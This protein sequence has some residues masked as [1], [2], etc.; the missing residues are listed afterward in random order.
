MLL[1]GS[2]V[3][4][5]LFLSLPLFLLLCMCVLNWLL[6]SRWGWSTKPISTKVTHFQALRLWLRLS[7]TL[8]FLLLYVISDVI[9]AVVVCDF[10][11]VIIIDMYVGEYVC[12]EIE[13]ICES[14]HT[15]LLSV[16][17]LLIFLLRK[18]IIIAFKYS[19]FVWIQ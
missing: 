13:S 2:F 17:I 14:I 19:L 6:R 9:V 15:Y 4:L 8:F 12:K 1:H 11:I 10:S 18:F 3:S 5:S 16:K 7:Y